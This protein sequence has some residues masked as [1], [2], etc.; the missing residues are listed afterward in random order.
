MLQSSCLLVASW[1]TSTTMCEDGSSI[2][3][4]DHEQQQA[5]GSIVTRYE[6][7]L[8]VRYY[9]FLRVRRSKTADR[10]RRAAAM[11]P[12]RAVSSEPSEITDLPA[13]RT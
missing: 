11:F 10:T 3:H 1:K 9:D 5:A 12:N 8:P 13:R 4:H 6:E 2:F 7:V